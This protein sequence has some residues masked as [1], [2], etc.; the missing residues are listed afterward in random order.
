MEFG[1]LAG[2]DVDCPCCLGV[3]PPDGGA[4][5]DAIE[6][7]EPTGHVAGGVNGGAW[8]DGGVLGAEGVEPC[9]LLFWPP[10]GPIGDALLERPGAAEEEDEAGGGHCGAPGLGDELNEVGNDE[11]EAECE[12]RYREVEV[13]GADAELAGS[14]GEEGEEGAGEEDGRRPTAGEDAGDREEGDDGCG[15]LLDGTAPA[16]EPAEVFAE[17][18]EELEEGAVVGPDVVAPGEDVAV[19]EGFGEGAGADED[20]DGEEGCEG[21]EGQPGWGLA[22]TPLGGD[23]EVP[24]DDDGEDDPGVFAVHGRD[25]EEHDG[26]GEEPPADGFGLGG[27]EEGEP[28]GEG[29]GQSEAVDGRDPGD[30]LVGAGVDGDDAGS[31]DA[32]GGA[33]IEAGGDEPGEDDRCEVAGEDDEV[34]RQGVAAS[35]GL[36]DLEPEEGE[37]PP[38]VAREW[39]EGFVAP[40]GEGGADVLPGAELA[41]GEEVEVVV[42]PKRGGERRGVADDGGGDDESEGPG[43]ACRPQEPVVHWGSLV[44]GRSVGFGGAVEEGSDGGGEG[45]VLGVLEVGVALEDAVGELAGAEEDFAVGEAGDAEH[46]VG[47]ALESAPGFA[48]AAHA[49]VDFGEGESVVGFAHGLE[50]FA[51]F[52]AWVFFAGEEDAVALFVAA[53]DAAAE[54]VELAEAESFGAFDDDDGGVGYIDSDFDDAG[55]DEDAGFVSGEASHD[56][57]FLASGHAT[58]E[59]IDSVAGEW[60]VAEEFEFFFGGADGE[61]FG[62]FDEGADDVG[63][64]AGV[65]AFAEEAVGVV[66]LVGAVPAGADGLAAGR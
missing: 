25:G 7:G 42:E 43:G 32:Y 21:E 34:V 35:D 29:E 33:G 4:E 5:I 1:D 18:E 45:C 17:G 20:V 3:L 22:E 30:G 16:I 11:G 26:E 64:F 8:R 14:D 10:T 62:F 24:A 52:G 50:A 13:A 36:E 53:A 54:L 28:G 41:G 66:A 65:E 12:R 37:G 51:G 23:G 15:E 39:Q 58:V 9:S 61:G 56:F 6:D 38:E 46:G 60:A 55:G 44:E 40:G 2:R 57:V 27:V 31:D 59:E 63:L 19:G 49:E 47:A 48:F